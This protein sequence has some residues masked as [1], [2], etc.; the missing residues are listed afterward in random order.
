[1]PRVPLVNEQ[2]RNAIGN[3]TNTL[4]K[5]YG[6]Q[7]A[8]NE[9]VKALARNPGLHSGN[10][11]RQNVAQAL[12][13]LTSIL[14]V[15][16]NSTIHTASGIDNPPLTSLRPRSGGTEPHGMASMVSTS[17]PYEPVSLPVTAIVPF[18][19]TIQKNA[20]VAKNEKNSITSIKRVQSNT[21]KRVISF[22]KRK[23]E[24]DSN[25]K[26]PN[27]SKELLISGI[28]HWIYD[29]NV[30]GDITPLHRMEDV[31]RC[32]LR[33]TGDF[34]SKKSEKL[35]HLQIE[36]VIAIWM[37]DTFLGESL[38][39]Y[40]SKKIVMDSNHRPF[41]I[42]DIKHILKLETLINSECFSIDN[43][44]FEWRGDL[45][46][47]WSSLLKRTLPIIFLDD[48]N[49]NDVA[50]D[51]NEFSHLYTGA[52]YLIDIK[53]LHDLHRQNVLYVGEAMWHIVLNEGINTDNLAYFFLP[54]I[55]FAASNKPEWINAREGIYKS[56]ESIINNYIEHR[57]H[58][59][60]LESFVEK[61]KKY[62]LAVNQWIDKSQLADKIIGG[63]PTGELPTLSD[64]ADPIRTQLQRREKAERHAKQFYMNGLMKPCKTAPESLAQEYERLTKNVADGFKEIDKYFISTAFYK[65]DNDDKAFITSLETTV[66]PVS[67]NMVSTKLPGIAYGFAIDRDIHIHL[68]ETDLF[69]VVSCDEER[70]YALK[71][72][73]ESELVKYNLIRL[74]KDIRRYVDSNILEN[75]DFS[76][77]TVTESNK[78]KSNGDVFDVSIITKLDNPYPKGNNEYF[79]IEKLSEIHR[80]QF[81]QR[82]YDKGN[83]PSDLQKV[84]E[85]VKHFIPFYDC[86]SGIKNNNPVEAVPACIFDFIAL[87]PVLGQA[88]R[89]GGRF[90]MGL[91]SGTLK[92]VNIMRYGGSLTARQVF[93]REMLMPASSEIRLLGIHTLRVLDPGFELLGGIGKKFS[94]KIIE[95]LKKGPNTA[96]IA[97]EIISSGA[98]EMLPVSQSHIV[99]A[100]YPNSDIKISVQEI[101]SETKQNLYVM[102]NTDTGE[103][104]GR[105]FYLREG[106]Q[107]EFTPHI[108]LKK[109]DVDL[110]NILKNEDE[111]KVAKNKI[112]EAPKEKSGIL[113]HTPRQRAGASRAATNDNVARSHVT[114]DVPRLTSFIPPRSDLNFINKINIEFIQLQYR[115]LVNYFP[116][117][118]REIIMGGNALSLIHMQCISDSEILIPD[119]FSYLKNN[120]ERYKLHIYNAKLTVN[121]VMMELD[122]LFNSQSLSAE[123]IYLRDNVVNDYL[124]RVLR[125]ESPDILSHAVERLNQSLKRICDYFDDYQ[126]KVYLVTAKRDDIFFADSPR[127]L[128]FTNIK[129]SEQ[130]IFIFSDCFDTGHGYND[131][132]LSTAVHEVTHTALGTQDFFY[133]PY[134][135]LVG[136]PEDIPEAF[137]EQLTGVDTDAPL[138]LDNEFLDAYAAH[139]GI[140]R[141]DI[142][143]FK[144]IILNDDM[145]KANII[146]DNADSLSNII[147]DL[148][149]RLLPSRSTRDVQSL[150]SQSRSFDRRTLKALI[151]LVA[152]GSGAR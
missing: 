92:S 22:L 32:I 142:E 106:D 29:L 146:M 4:D 2:Y 127:V 90:G 15:V 64:K 57:K 71:K 28:A 53:Q 112:P 30:S 96:K 66:Y 10:H 86:I 143:S 84:W 148:H 91:V 150:P 44:P 77:Y 113:F 37:F 1:M 45:N 31:A 111:H 18:T 104:S 6:N 129:D 19:H 23:G 94:T 105:Y 95:S 151:G 60:E 138:N 133:S 3:Y 43:V 62:E 87:I 78:I 59:I 85:V 35:S 33:G 116:N 75:Y 119:A 109:D 80:E 56:T 54:A 134:T 137:V 34:G 20:T 52:R 131:D 12:V 9:R 122:Y 88:V 47:M 93:F 89:L 144:H 107:L 72:D 98:L 114:V 26:I 74:D 16:S 101:H 67:F 49:I 135:N 21:N 65:L 149:E 17:T 24:I 141:P 5:K 11:N 115:V 76:N 14:S 100:R 40:L 25:V 99:S 41:T 121:N 48:E 81:Y 139:M 97:D 50:I 79:I 132:M 130:R 117:S 38:N 136:E 27:V 126:D 13:Q 70:I 145:L 46:K 36:K 8:Q 39:E 110:I 82:L 103:V 152:V 128:G 69:A 147:I 7:R 102:V 42:A 120:F 55:F 118:Y 123:K 61:L 140:E 51:S 124:K 58:F 63:C 68:N 83:N 108:K 73:T 125:T